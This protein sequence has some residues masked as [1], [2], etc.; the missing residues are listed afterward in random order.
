[1]QNVVKSTAVAACGLVTSLITAVLVTVVQLTTGFDLFS[2]SV[3][4]IV[5]IGAIMVGFA[6]ASGYYFGSLYFHTRPTVLLFFQMVI[7]AGLTQ[8]LIYYLEYVTFVLPDGRRVSDYIGFGKYLNITLTTAHYRFGRAMADTGEIGQAGYWLAA[9]QFVGFLFGGLCAFAVLIGHPTC[10][11]CKKYLR[12]LGTSSKMF[13][14]APKMAEYH[15]ALFTLPVDSA[16]FAAK[17]K[18]A[19]DT[20][21]EKGACRLTMKLRGCPECKDQAIQTEVQVWNGHDWKT[22][23]DLARRYNIPGGISLVNVYRS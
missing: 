18:E 7:V 2:L 10:A 6:A 13:E 3:W 12:T 14:D 8:L 22:I 5:P 21:G 17:V 1:V 11:K 20:K 16:E 9:V 19:H 4:V 15:D 23:N